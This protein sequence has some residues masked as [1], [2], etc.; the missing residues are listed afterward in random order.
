MAESNLTENYRLPAW[1]VAAKRWQGI[2]LGLIWGGW[3]L[4]LCLA[5]LA[6]L[7]GLDWLWLLL[8]GQL[9]SIASLVGAT[10]LTLLLASPLYRWSHTLIDL[11]FFPDTTRLKEE[12]DRACQTLIHINTRADLENFLITKLPVRLQVEFI[13]MQEKG[14]HDS[15]P[16]VRLPL[17]MG[18]RFLGTLAIGPKCSG[19]SFDTDEMAALERLGE[20]V[21]L[22]LSV[23]QLQEARETAERVDRLKNNFLTNISHEL[24]TPLNA[25]INSTG[26]VADEMLGPLDETQTIYLRRAVDGSEHL[27]KLLD[28]ILDITRLEAGELRLQLERFD[29]GE[30]IEAVVPMVQAV[31]ADKPV[32]FEIDLPDDLPHIVADRLRVRQILLNLLS[33]AIKFTNDGSISIRA[34]FKKDKVFVSVEDTGVGIAPDDLSLIFEDYKQILRRGNVDKLM[35]RRRHLGTGLGMPIAKALVELHGG[36]ITVHSEVNAGSIFTFSLPAVL[37]AE[38]P[39]S[40]GSPML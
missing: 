33:N 21:A 11:F 36:Q 9:R 17:E 15:S 6:I 27:M 26:L 30:I 18:E 29:I 34:R 2:R 14:G 8:A 31:L 10:L 28:E 20:Q 39:D 3:G 35:S 4:A 25:V 22:V 38:E 13:T 40:P 7:T 24:R 19:R 37:K 23:L 32:Q 16:G 1:P 12:S 5:F